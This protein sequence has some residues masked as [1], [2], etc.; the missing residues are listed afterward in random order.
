MHSRIHFVSGGERTKFNKK[1]A[2]KNGEEYET[3]KHKETSGVLIDQEAGF[4]ENLMHYIYQVFL[5]TSKTFLSSCDMI[6][7]DSKILVYRI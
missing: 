5:S 1:H 6:P 2:D 4:W 3:F 7:N